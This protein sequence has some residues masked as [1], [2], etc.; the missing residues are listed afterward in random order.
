[1]YFHRD[2]IGNSRLGQAQFDE[3]IMHRKAFGINES[4]HTRVLKEA[5]FAA[6]EGLIPQDVYQDFDNDVI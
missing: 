2:L 1:M 5:G 3:V 6:N 4:I